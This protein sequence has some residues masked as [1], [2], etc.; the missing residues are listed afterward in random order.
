MATSPGNPHEHAAQRGATDHAVGPPARAALTDP[1]P[2]AARARRLGAAA[3]VL[4]VLTVGLR[5]CVE[6]LLRPAVWEL[7]TALG[8][9]LLALAT[10]AAAA[11]PTL[12]LARGIRRHP[13]P[14]TFAVATASG[15][16]PRSSEPAFAALPTPWWGVLLLLYLA[17]ATGALPV[18]RTAAGGWSA[19][20]TTV[21]AA[22]ALL[23]P[24]LAVALYHRWRGPRV[25]LTA[26]GLLLR[27]LRDG[28]A[29]LLVPWPKV[30]LSAVAGARA[31][32]LPVT[33]DGLA[34]GVSWLWLDPLY[35]ARAL[36][37]YADH[38]EHR[39]AIGTPLELLRLRAALAFSPDD[40]PVGTWEVPAPR[41]PRDD[42]R[43]R[44]GR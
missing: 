1:G 5:L 6:L 44:T 23:L 42:T 17:L 16:A 24:P 22:A 43:S 8:L 14:R 19:D 32:R 31:R 4:A 3:A 36:R 10:V 25:S 2:L 18:D 21:L 33:A 13:L 27:R 12:L 38:P 28:R 41:A 37:H 20:G 29:G 7:P 34:V 40:P 11:V 15:S 39:A 30:D 26:D 35:L 9:P